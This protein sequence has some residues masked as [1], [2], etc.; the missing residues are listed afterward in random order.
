MGSWYIGASDS[1][2]LQLNRGEMGY[3]ADQ[4]GG[5]INGEHIVIAG[6]AHVLR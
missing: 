1:L 5:Y 4:L 6:D 3:K 2:Q